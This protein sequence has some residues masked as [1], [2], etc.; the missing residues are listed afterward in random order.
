MDF[1]IIKFCKSVERAFLDYSNVGRDINF[2]DLRTEGSKCVCC[3]A[4]TGL[5]GW[6]TK[7]S[8]N[9]DNIL[10]ANNYS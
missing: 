9:Y 3:N 1:N 2:I 6:N 10:T 7:N 5:R 8:V 4:C